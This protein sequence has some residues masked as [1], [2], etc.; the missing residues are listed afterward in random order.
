MVV[1]FQTPQEEE[2]GDDFFHDAYQEQEQHQ[3]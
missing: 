3:G 1:R 2:E